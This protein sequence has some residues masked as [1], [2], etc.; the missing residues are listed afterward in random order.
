MKVGPNFVTK[1]HYCQDVPYQILN[2]T[3][4]CIWPLPSLE[5]DCF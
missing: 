1:V 3:E 5:Q 4:L 2:E